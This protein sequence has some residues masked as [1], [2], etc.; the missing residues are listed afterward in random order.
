MNRRGRYWPNFGHIRKTLGQ[1]IYCSGGYFGRWR[2]KYVSIRGAIF[3][4]RLLGCS[5]A[6]Q[7]YTNII[8]NIKL[9]PWDLKGLWRWV[10]NNWVLWC[11]AIHNCVLWCDTTHN[12][13]LWC[14]TIH[15]LVNSQ[16]HS[17]NAWFTLI[18]EDDFSILKTYAYGSFETSAHICRTQTVVIIRN[19]QRIWGGG[20]A[21]TTSP[22]TTRPSTTFYRLLLNWASLRR[23]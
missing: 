23:H 2:A 20:L 7:L 13:V 11:D 9:A 6:T 21:C 12:C 18:N 3:M 16:R 17:R 22:D 19:F 5:T 10:I 15:T 8:Q 4:V 14:D 1:N